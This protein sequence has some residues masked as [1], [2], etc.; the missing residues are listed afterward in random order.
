M[1]ID[2]V[3]RGVYS[4][5]AAQQLAWFQKYSRTVAERP[6]VL[7]TEISFAVGAFTGSD[8]SVSY[9]PYTKQ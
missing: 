2:G 1:T 3:S 7:A 8:Q 5:L 4:N 6:N 9:S